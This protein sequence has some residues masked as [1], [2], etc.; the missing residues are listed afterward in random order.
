M[1]VIIYSTPPQRHRRIKYSS[2]CNHIRA[3]HVVIVFYIA[4][5]PYASDVSCERFIL[6]CRVL[7]EKLVVAQPVRPVKVKE[8]KNGWDVN[9]YEEMTNTFENLGGKP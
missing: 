3:F 2:C 8:D 9:A 4:E 1:L 7:K 5:V 6:S